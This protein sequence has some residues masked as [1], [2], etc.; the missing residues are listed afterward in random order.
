MSLTTCGL[1]GAQL[2]WLVHGEA[3]R[4]A[5]PTPLYA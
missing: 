5:S 2:F 3:I 1:A 4:A